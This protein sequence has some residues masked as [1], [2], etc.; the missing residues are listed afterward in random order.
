VEAD[1]AELARARHPGQPA[2]DDPTASALLERLGQAATSPAAVG[3]PEL[4]AWHALGLAERTRQQ[5]LSDPAAWAAAVAAWERLDQ[6]Y[7]IA[8]AGFRQAEALLIAGDRDRAAAVL[9]RAAEVTGRLGARL[10][11][12]E[13][14]AL[15]GVPAWTSPSTPSPRRLACRRPPRSSA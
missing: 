12:G 1:R 15:A 10:L 6:A 9:G 8:Y 2:P 4:A 11:D 5:G 7:R 13:I 3:L 14:Q